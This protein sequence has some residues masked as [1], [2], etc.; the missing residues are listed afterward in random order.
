MLRLLVGGR[1]ESSDESK[2]R[3]ALHAEA[4]TSPGFHLHLRAHVWSPTCRNRHAAPFSRQPAV[5]PPDDPP[6]RPKR[7]HSSS[8]RCPP[9]HRDSPATR[10]LA[11]PRMA[12]Y[13]NVKITG[14]NH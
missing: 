1:D 10:K 12:R 13:Q 8:A 6:P 4:G 3:R 11:H 2:I 7:I 14:L 9:E 5:G